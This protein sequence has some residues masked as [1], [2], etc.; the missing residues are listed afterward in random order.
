[1]SGAGSP[2]GTSAG[3]IPATTDVLPEKASTLA[4]MLP[5]AVIN[6]EMSAIVCRDRGDLTGLQYGNMQ[7]ATHAKW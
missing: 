1:M 2:T 3:S 5:A 6:V 4:E 7:H